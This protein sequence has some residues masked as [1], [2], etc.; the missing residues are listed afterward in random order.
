MEYALLDAI[1]TRHTVR[2]LNTREVSVTL[3]VAEGFI[4]VAAVLTQRLI[5]SA[6]RIPCK[7]TGGI[8]TMDERKVTIVTTAVNLTLIFAVLS[9]LVLS[10]FTIPNHIAKVPHIKTAGAITALKES[11]LLAAAGLVLLASGEHLVPRIRTSC[12]SVADFC[13]VARKTWAGHGAL[14][15]AK[16]AT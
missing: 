5:C 11:V 14:L 6:A 10:V 12:N 13:A 2:I 16:G 1:R 7:N 8:V 15:Y 4:H 9:A 3:A